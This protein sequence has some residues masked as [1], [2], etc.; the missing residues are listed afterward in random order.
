M[1]KNFRNYLKHC[2]IWAI[3]WN[4]CVLAIILVIIILFVSFYRA[5]HYIIFLA[6][7]YSGL[8]SLSVAF[9]TL[10][11]CHFPR[12]NLN[13]MLLQTS[14]LCISF[15]GDDG[16]VERLATL[17]TE[18]QHSAVEIEEISADKS[19]RS[20][21][22]KTPGSEIFYFWCSEKSK[23]LGNELLQKV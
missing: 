4:L 16:C 9:W 15:A 10:F 14:E 3:F 13:L 20:F 21:L 11:V 1:R 19:G 22:I 23:L 2:L 18:T 7:I 6:W 5:M 12:G 17:S 8:F